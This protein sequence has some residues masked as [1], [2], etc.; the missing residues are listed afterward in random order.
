MTHIDPETKRAI[1]SKFARTPEGW[2]KLL[3]A[4]VMP[5]MTKFDFFASGP[6]S[7]G[8][9]PT[10]PVQTI[11]REFELRVDNTDAVQNELLMW[12]LE[13]VDGPLIQSI[14]DHY[15]AQ[16]IESVKLAQQLNNSDALVLPGHPLSG[17]PYPAQDIE[18]V[19]LA[20]QINSDALVLFE[21]FRLWFSA[22]LP[23]DTIIV[24]THNLESTPG[25]HREHIQF[26]LVGTTPEPEGDCLRAQVQASFSWQ[27]DLP[28]CVTVYHL[29]P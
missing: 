13:K 12:L 29:I 17:A 19:K 14:L 2:E 15:P 7:L 25:W 11:T 22:R 16:D 9:R 8:V 28:T 21:E 6:K 1:L 5:L 20:Q 18:S 24:R 3:A 23:E 27:A 26:K 10:S 4:M